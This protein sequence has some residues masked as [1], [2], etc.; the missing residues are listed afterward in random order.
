MARVKIQKTNFTGGEVTPSL[1]GRGDLTAYENGAALLRNV[2]VRPTGS[3]VRRSGLRYVDSLS[4][5]GRLAAFE[6]STEQTYLL[7]FLDQAVRVYEN[8]AQTATIATPWAETHL[9]QVTWTQSA[10][11]LLVVHP[12][13]PPKR[14][15]RTSDVGWR[16]DDWSF[17]AHNNGRV[18]MPHYKFAGEAVTLSRNGETGSIALSASDYVFHPD[19]RGTRFRFED[20]EVVIDDV[21]GAGG[22]SR[23]GWYNRARATVIQSLG[24]TATTTRDWSE[25]VFSRVRGWPTSVTFHQDRLII[26]GSRSL[27]NTLW[28]SKSSDLFNFDEGTGLDDEAIQFAILSDQVNAIRAVFSGRHLQVFTSGAEWM[29]TGDPLTPTSIQLHR[30]TRIGSPV[31]RVVQPRDIDGATIFV[32]RNNSQLREFV[33]ADVEQAYQAADLALLA[34]H[35]VNRPVDMDYDQASRLLHLAMSDGTLGTLTVYRAEQI[36]AWTLQETDGRFLCVVVAGDEVYT[37]VER[38][39]AYFLE[40]FDEGLHV[41]SGLAGASEEPATSWGSLDH[42]ESQRLFVVADGAVREPVT[43]VDGEIELDEPAVSVQ[44]GLPFAHIVKPLPAQ[45]RGSNGVQGRQVRPVSVTFRFEETC[46]LKLDLGRGLFEVPLERLGHRRLDRGPVPYSGDKKIR[47]T[48]WYQNGA[49]AAWR[50]EQ[51][52]PLPFSLLSVTTEISVND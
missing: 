37:L 34:G 27:P 46:A 28:L 4:G 49:A 50:I 11:T 42:L 52:V 5:P 30:Q 8:G 44:A 39:A 21:E 17:A 22:N 2:F 47:T 41:D 6:F 20:R 29:V 12:D 38:H 3:V 1:L 14:I 13:V 33:F 43:V 32:P 23:K 24:S 16:L 7:A 25:Q 40:A 36:T 18:F 9:K 31:D 10:D 51:D 48:G 19:H 45:V 35:I 15:T 26:G